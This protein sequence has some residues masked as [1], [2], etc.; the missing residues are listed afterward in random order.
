MQYVSTLR[1]LINSSRPR[2]SVSLGS[3]LGLVTDLRSLA[4]TNRDN[5][6]YIYKMREH[7]LHPLLK[8]IWEI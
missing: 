4:Q 6:V 5:S 8:D 1:T 3:M 2:P 7:M